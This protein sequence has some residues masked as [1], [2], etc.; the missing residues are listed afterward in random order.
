LAPLHNAFCKNQVD[1]LAF[2]HNELCIKHVDLFIP[3][4]GMVSKNIAKMCDA[5]EARFSYYFWSRY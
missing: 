5:C 3:G 1:F 4:L 2:L